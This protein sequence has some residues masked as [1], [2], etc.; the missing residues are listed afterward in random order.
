MAHNSNSNVAADIIAKK[1]RRI[2]VIALVF[3][4]TITRIRFAAIKIKF[5]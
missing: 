4:A 5:Y 2:S 3:R 1:R